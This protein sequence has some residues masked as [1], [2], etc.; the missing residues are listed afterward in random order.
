MQVGSQDAIVLGVDAAEVEAETG[1]GAATVGKQNEISG[2]GKAGHR[3]R[4]F[5]KGPKE[6][7][8]GLDTLIFRGVP[9]EPELRLAG[10]FARSEASEVQI[11]DGYG[12]DVLGERAIVGI[13]VG[14]ERRDVLD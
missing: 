3:A 12:F 10:A 5:R 7:K 11:T 1:H 6:T 2:A 14:A 13:E 8:R 9:F 4:N